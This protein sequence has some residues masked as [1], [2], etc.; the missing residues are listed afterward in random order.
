MEPEKPAT[1]LH[2][3]T[4]KGWTPE[5]GAVTESVIY[6]AEFD[7]TVNK[8]MVVFRNHDGSELQADS[9]AYGEV[10]A[11]AGAT[12]TKAATAQYTYTFKGWNPA[13]DTVKAD[14]EY[15]AQFDSTVN[16]YRIVFKNHNGVVL[17][18]DSVAYRRPVV[19]TALDAEK[20]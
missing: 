10:P 15:V 17:A 6:L 8:F 4:F 11:Y 9:V 5:I 18:S 19:V 3:Y 20:T 1:D 7:S 13:I 14:A 12:P 16:E 2:T